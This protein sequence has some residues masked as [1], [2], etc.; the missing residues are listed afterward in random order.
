MGECRQS[1]GTIAKAVLAIAGLIVAVLGTYFAYRQ[2]QLSRSE[3]NEQDPQIVV[4]LHSLSYSR[5]RPQGVGDDLAYVPAVRTG[6][7]L[8]NKRASAAT[9]TKVM[10]NP[11]G[12][13]KDGRSGGM[14]SLEVPL[15]QAVPGYGAVDVRD[16]S[17]TPNIAI[18]EKAWIDRP[19]SV[20]VRAYW[21]GTS[22]PMLSCI[23]NS[24][25]RWNCGEKSVRAVL[26][27]SACQ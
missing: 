6:F 1:G 22:G 17:F 8:V 4:C 26:V 25:R 5:G 3:S 13:W 21:A 24:G 10:L 16:L 20:N 2:Y 23:S 27:D 9:V 12:K 19:E 14:G 15:N 18:S 7:K 11:V